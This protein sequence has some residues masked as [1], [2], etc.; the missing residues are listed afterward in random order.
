[1]NSKQNIKVD[2]KRHYLHDGRYD[3]VC[4]M[5][6]SLLHSCTGKVHRVDYAESTDGSSRV[7]FVV[8]N[9]NRH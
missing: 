2:I 8:E 6:E 3:M 5:L 4:R 9:S 1:M 7:E